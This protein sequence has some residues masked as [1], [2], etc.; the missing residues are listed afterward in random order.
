MSS[1][2]NALPGDG[3]SDLP[4]SAPADL[5]ARGRPRS[6]STREVRRAP[7]VFAVGR[8][9]QDPSSALPGDAA[10]VTDECEMLGGAAAPSRTDHDGPVVV[11]CRQHHPR[12][13]E[14]ASQYRLP[15]P[16]VPFGLSASQ[17]V[18]A[19]HHRR[20]GHI[21]CG[22]LVDDE[23]AGAG[24]HGFGGRSGRSPRRV[25]L[26]RLAPTGMLCRGPRRTTWRHGSAPPRRADGTAPA[27]GPRR[28][29]RL[30][31]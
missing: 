13:D 28:Y 12:P 10:A 16:R 2:A 11:G 7:L 15:K 27:R 18:R 29:G 30:K 19:P 6:I 23:T 31:S 21:G 17:R 9:R 1:L 8:C 5:A 14:P 20:H 24:C 22:W 3:D 4:E 26:C 25:D